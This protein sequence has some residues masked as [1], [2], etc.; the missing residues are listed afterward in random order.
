MGADCSRM[1]P[2]F[3]ATLF[4]ATIIAVSAQDGAAQA[5]DTELS[6]Q[7][8]EDALALARIRA[9]MN[10][11]DEPPTEVTNDEYRHG[12]LL[13]GE[14][15]D[16]PQVY[17]YTGRGQKEEKRFIFLN[18]FL[19]CQKLV[20]SV[21]DLFVIVMA[22]FATIASVVNTVSVSLVSIVTTINTVVNAILLTIVAPIVSIVNCFV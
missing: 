4:L 1:S 21:V 12:G 11:Q 15:H 10:G 20:S 14:D 17:V 16:L 22:V 5:G 3:L 6:E 7:E 13:L 8:K 2:V 18:F 19:S 9:A